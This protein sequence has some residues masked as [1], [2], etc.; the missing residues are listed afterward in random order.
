LASFPEQFLIQ[1]SYSEKWAW[2]GNSAPPLFM[3]AIAE[4]IRFHLAFG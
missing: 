2:V 1:G 4:H 3:K